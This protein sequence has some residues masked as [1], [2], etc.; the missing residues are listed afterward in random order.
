MF[1]RIMIFVAFFQLFYDL[2]RSS[3]TTLP[4]VTII[5]NAKEEILESVLSEFRG[6]TFFGSVKTP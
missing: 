1:C 4:S 2:Q 3:D 5:R 6:Y